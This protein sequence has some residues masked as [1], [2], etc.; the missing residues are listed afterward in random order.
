MRK[1]IKC[2]CIAM[3]A[4]T[5]GLFPIRGFSLGLQQ[6]KKQEKVKQTLEIER[7][8]LE[9][10]Y[11]KTLR[12]IVKE[13]IELE[14][15]EKK[16]QK[17][18]EE[19]KK[20]KEE[21]RKKQQ[22][23]K[24]KLEYVAK[25]GEPLALALGKC[26]VALKLHFVDQG[27]RKS[28]VRDK[29]FSPLPRNYTREECDAVKMLARTQVGDFLV[30]EKSFENKAVWE[31][32]DYYVMKYRVGGLVERVKK[33]I[34]D[35]LVSDD[36]KAIVYPD[37]VIEV[38]DCKKGH[39]N[40]ER[41]LRNLIENDYYFY[42]YELSIKIDGKDYKYTGELLPAVESRLGTDGI[43]VAGSVLH[44]PTGDKIPV[45]VYYSKNGVFVDKTIMVNVDESEKEVWDGDVCINL[46]LV[47]K[48]QNFLKGL[49]MNAKP[50][51]PDEQLAQKTF[52]N[53]R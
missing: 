16:A 3:I 39:E 17:V 50:V 22:T 10:E 40:V 35:Y 46:K 14:E 2:F 41:F 15:A 38:W 12:M 24:Q 21:E 31:L 8:A 37:G 1:G 5:L 23:K 25:K 26:G 6:S 4:A 52:E 7:R 9:K 34:R 18:A 51:Y 42:S 30:R 19:K 28:F 29:L 36:A 43:I 27:K 13:Y 45:R 33:K 53:G 47:D 11:V 44:D 49:I 20:K 32:S 48:K